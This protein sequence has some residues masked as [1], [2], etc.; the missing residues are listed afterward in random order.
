MVITFSC[1]IFWFFFFSK[2][3]I[4]VTNSFFFSQKDEIFSKNIIETSKFI[5]TYP[6]FLYDA[7]M[8]SLASSLGQLFINH[9]IKD[10]GP[11]T[12]SLIMTLRQFLSLLLSA[13]IFLHPLTILQMIG[14]TIVFIATYGQSFVLNSRSKPSSTLS[15]SSSSTT[16]NIPA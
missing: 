15:S 2:T 11:V 6:H 14:A 1:K 5:I 12:N 4:Q 13:I 7:A 9:T 16:V 3:I 8:L 10:F